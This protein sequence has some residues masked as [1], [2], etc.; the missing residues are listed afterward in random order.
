MDRHHLTEEQVAL[1]LHRAAEIDH[2]EPGADLVAVAAVEE[3]AVEAGLSR[4]AVRRALAELAAGALDPGGSLGPPR[5]GGCPTLVVRR[6]VPG[7]ARAVSALVDDFLTGQLFEQRRVTGDWARWARREDLSA[8]VKRSVDKSVQ[9]KV[10]LRDARWVDVAIGTPGPDADEALVRLE[11]DMAPLR[12]PHHALVAWGA[13]LG[14]AATG[15]GVLAAGVHPATVAAVPAATVGLGSAGHGIGLRR[16]RRQVD[17]LETA[18]EG[19]LDRVERRPLPAGTTA[20]QLP[21]ATP[22]GSGRGV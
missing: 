1:V 4:E 14:A 22:P 13:G 21:R 15:I 6:S 5:L 10:V 2:P 11:V 16:F 3:A 18:L 17:D 19:F 8:R 20:R 12:R 9:R 7:P